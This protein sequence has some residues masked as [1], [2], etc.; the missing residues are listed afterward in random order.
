VTG[1]SEHWDDRY[2]RRGPVPVGHLG[3]PPVFT[4]YVSEF[5]CAGTALDIACGQ[6]SAAVWLAQRGMAVQGVDVSAVAVAHATAL[7][8]EAGVA[9][10]CRF[11]VADL[12]DGLP[13]GPAGDVL[14]CHLF[15]DPRLDGALLGRLAPGG[16]LA[17]AAL[18]E[19]GGAP[20]RFRAR[21][22]ELAAAFGGLTVI[23][24][25]EGGGTAWLLGRR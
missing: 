5:P 25:W 16:L 18:S 14:L 6:G 21:P 17:I 22:G 10:R 3:P 13:P 9:E 19:V 20:G 1:S 8:S 2:A 15:R 4:P 12:D 7:A 23:A 24:A 11:D